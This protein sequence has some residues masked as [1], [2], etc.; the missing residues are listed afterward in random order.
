MAR[1][2]KISIRESFSGDQEEVVTAI[3]NGDGPHFLT[4]DAGSGKSYIIRYLQETVKGCVVT[5]MTGTAAQLIG[6]RTIHSFA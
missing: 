4:G 1:K 3:E 2:K 5:A 6:G